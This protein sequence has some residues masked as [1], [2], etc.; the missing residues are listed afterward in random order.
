MICAPTSSGKTVLSSCVADTARTRPVQET[1]QEKGNIH[2][3]TE[4]KEKLNKTQEK[5]P[6]K[7][8]ISSSGGRVAGGASVCGTQKS[9]SNESKETVLDSALS[10]QE[11]I[12]FI[13][14]SDPLVWQVA[15]HFA[16]C[17]GLDSK[18]AMVTD[19]FVYTPTLNNSKQTTV[20]VGTPLALESAL[21]RIRS[22]IAGEKTG[23]PEDDSEIAKSVNI[24]A[25][26][27]D[28]YK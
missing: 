9:G 14:P 5:Y 15:A 6:K 23:S 4:E 12:L 20:V 10:S 24:L 11:S 2:E 13:V 3:K 1:E 19:R 25:G 22:G 7:K 26:G 18:V 16:K 17:R 28:H 21:T 8:H 27:F